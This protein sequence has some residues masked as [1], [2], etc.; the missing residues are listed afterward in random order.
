ME[1]QVDL[2]GKLRCEIDEWDNMVW[3]RAGMRHAYP[4]LGVMVLRCLSCM[5]LVKILG[6][7]SAVDPNPTLREKEQDLKWVVEKCECDSENISSL[8]RVCLECGKIW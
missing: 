1:I 2:L 8:C 6:P 7:D 5:L 4:R 3:T